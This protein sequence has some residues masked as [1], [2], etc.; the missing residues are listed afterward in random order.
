MCS[1]S[2][3][4][5]SIIDNYDNEQGN[6][7]HKNFQNIHIKNGLLVIMTS[8][9]SGG[10]LAP[11]ALLSAGKLKATDSL[12]PP[13]S[14]EIPSRSSSSSIVIGTNVYTYSQNIL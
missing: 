8:T 1:F 2:Q 6:R 5:K 9:I 4:H 13:G 7:M 11:S 10:T 14:E 3:E 12:F